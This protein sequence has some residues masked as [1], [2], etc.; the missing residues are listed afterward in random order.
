MNIDYKPGDLVELVPREKNETREL[1]L[2]RI[3]LYFNH[4]GSV[5]V[6]GF[7]EYK[8]YVTVLIGSELKETPIGWWKKA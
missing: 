7:S 8:Y 5:M 2:T 3:E 4:P 1:K 6:I